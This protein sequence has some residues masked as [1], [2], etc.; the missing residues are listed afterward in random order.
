MKTPRATPPVPKIPTVQHPFFE[1]AHYENM[2]GT[3]EVLALAGSTMRI[4]WENGEESETDVELQDRILNRFERE[5][6]FAGVRPASFQD[7]PEIQLDR[8][9]RGLLPADFTLDITKTTWRSR[10]GGLG[11]AV[12]REFAAGELCF[13]FWVPFRQPTIVWTDVTQKAKNA[14]QVRAGFFCRL[15][16]ARACCGFFLH[17]PGETGDGGHWDRFL[18][19]L[20]VAG[21]EEWLL[22]LAKEHGLA[23]SDP[24]VPDSL[25]QAAKARWVLVDANGRTDVPSLGAFLRERPAEPGG[26]FELAVYMDKDRAVKRELEFGRDIAK[27]FTALL[28][29]YKACLGVAAASKPAAARKRKR[30]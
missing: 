18:D 14:E 15:E 24:Q 22:A 26:A 1:G 23:V 9:F 16:E 25:L 5:V 3:Y 8:P 13:G 27:L 19:W 11:G 17:R 4:R 30:A 20:G 7:E 12:M 28:P 2:K 29:L 6:R 21:H 10:T